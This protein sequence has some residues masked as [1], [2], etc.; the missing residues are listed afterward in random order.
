MASTDKPT[1]P[2]VPP[3]P[4]PRPA[5]SP[6]WTDCFALDVALRV[7]LLAAAITAVVVMVTSQQTKPSSVPS[8]INSPIRSPA[9]FNHSPAFIYF[10]AALSV[11]GL[12][13]IIT[14]IASISVI[15]KPEFSKKFLLHF[16][17]WD[18]LILGVVAS[19]V[20]AAGAIAYTELKGNS[21]VTWIKV[22][23]VYDR[24]CKHLAAS[25]A[26]ALFAAVLLAL[27]A[28]LSILSLH[29]RIRD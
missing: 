2:E 29:K 11:A 16:A 28:I 27:L 1:D 23:S 21:H 17:F 18:L 24:H 15:L 26:V 20:G 25:L 13:S 14:I 19:A 9:K 10:V 5:P 3:P 6:C 7:L 4:P 12:Y 8:A 22:C